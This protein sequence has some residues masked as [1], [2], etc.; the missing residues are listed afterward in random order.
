[1]ET[2]KFH[3]SFEEMGADVR[4]K[5]EKYPEFGTFEERQARHHGIEELVTLIPATPDEIRRMRK[6][7]DKDAGRRGND[8]MA[9]DLNNPWLINQT[10]ED[11]LDYISRTIAERTENAY[12]D[13]IAY[14]FPHILEEIKATYGSIP[15]VK[16]SPY[17]DIF[18]EE[19]EPHLIDTISRLSSFEVYT[20]Y[21]KDQESGAMI[22]FLERNF[23]SILI[24][25][26]AKYEIPMTASSS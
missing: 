10:K 12:L 17:T 20:I 6:E 15:P 18:A 11:S 3:G 16:R 25:I 26:K 21:L 23:P 9:D 8:I 4:A 19:D 14:N 7:G 5:I 2:D 22:S 1:M 13:F 24:E